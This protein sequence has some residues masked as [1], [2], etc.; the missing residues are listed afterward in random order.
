[1]CTACP[2]GRYADASG[3]SECIQVPGGEYTVDEND[4]PV[5]SGAVS[6][7]KCAVGRHSDT[8]STACFDCPAG[9]V[10]STEGMGACESCGSGSVS[11]LTAQTSCLLATAGR[12]TANENGRAS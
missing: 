6:T 11:N 7:A 10:G 8:G 2:S 12:Y 4:S 9:K 5:Q 3:L 1:M